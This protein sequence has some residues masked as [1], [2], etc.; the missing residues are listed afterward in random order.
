MKFRKRNRGVLAISF[1]VGFLFASF[2]PS[3]LL[4][5]ILSLAVICL[6]VTCAKC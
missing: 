5:I 1:G 3:Q 6:G 2:C 4:I